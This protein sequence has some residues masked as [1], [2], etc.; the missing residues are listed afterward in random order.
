M[1]WEIGGRSGYTLAQMRESHKGQDY[2]FLPPSKLQ[3]DMQAK[4]AHKMK[5]DMENPTRDSG[6]NCKSDAVY[7]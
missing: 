6:K 1:V 4:M 5:V 3:I 2:I 7:P